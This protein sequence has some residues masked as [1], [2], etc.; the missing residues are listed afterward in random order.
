MTVYAV[1]FDESDG[2][3]VGYHDQVLILVKDE[4][5][6]ERIIDGLIGK[7]KHVRTGGGSAWG[8]FDGLRVEEMEVW[9]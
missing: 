8:K 9:G 2:Y 1:M 6:G 7:S 4:E 5:T 3:D